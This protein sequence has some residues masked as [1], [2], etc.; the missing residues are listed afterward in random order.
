MGY[1]YNDTW[2]KT[3]LDWSQQPG[4]GLHNK[5]DKEHQDFEFKKFKINCPF[6][7]LNSNSLSALMCKM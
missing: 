6:I 5:V 4:W 7:F 3:E 2:S 1:N